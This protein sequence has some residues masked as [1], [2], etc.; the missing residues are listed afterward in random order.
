MKKSKEELKTYFET[1]DKPTQEQYSD[2][3]DS[4]IDAKQPEGEPNRRFVI[5]ETGEV[6]LASGSLKNYDLNFTP[7]QLDFTYFG[8]HVY[9]VLLPIPEKNSDGEYVFNHSL[10]IETYLKIELWE[11]GLASPIQPSSNNVPSRIEVKEL[12]K[13]ADN[14]VLVFDANTVNIKLTPSSDVNLNQR[15]LYVEFMLPSEKF[16]P[17]IQ[18]VSYGFDPAIHDIN[19]YKLRE[20]FSFASALYVRDQQRNTIPSTVIDHSSVQI[21]EP[22]PRTSKIVIGFE[23]FD[24]IYFEES[25]VSNQFDIQI[26][27]S[28]GDF[29]N[30]VIYLPVAYYS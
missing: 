12:L 21:T 4:Y 29:T 23:A 11:N 27:L 8:E 1:G 10:G 30:D 7:A 24:G 26:T 9:G 18:F 13:D 14:D 20:S 15:L 28:N 3:I 22:I 25:A 2:L 17:K 6:S 16:T 19:D 5:D